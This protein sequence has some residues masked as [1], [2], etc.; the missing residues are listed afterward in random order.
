M[1]RVNITIFAKFTDAC[2]FLWRVVR[3]WQRILQVDM[4]LVLIWKFAVYI[5]V[6]RE[7]TW[8]CVLTRSINSIYFMN[9]L[10]QIVP[11]LLDPTYV[12]SNNR[13]SLSSPTPAHEFR[14]SIWCNACVLYNYKTAAA[15]LSYEVRQWYIH[16]VRRILNNLSKN[17][18]TSFRTFTNSS[19]RACMAVDIYLNIWRPYYTT[20]YSE[21]NNILHLL[22]CFTSHYIINISQYW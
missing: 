6:T 5:H 9:K 13:P 4:A 14:A 1:V 10:N 21:I 20:S 18:P 12:L 11:F 22:M 2:D 19:F 15:E 7:R 3:S 8:I 17:L 16:K